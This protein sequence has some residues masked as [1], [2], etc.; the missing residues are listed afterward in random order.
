M[1]DEGI[2][3]LEI[4]NVIISETDLKP[5]PSALSFLW[6]PE[7]YGHETLECQIPDFRD[8]LTPANQSS[9]YMPMAAE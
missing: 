9:P 7:A 5:A 2:V 8:S 4:L 6:K 1:Q 3:Y